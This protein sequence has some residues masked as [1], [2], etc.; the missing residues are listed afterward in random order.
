MCLDYAISYT[1]GKKG[2]PHRVPPTLME[3]ANHSLE[4]EKREIAISSSSE[5]DEGT[6]PK[7]TP[8]SESR[9]GEILTDK[10][11]LSPVTGK[12]ATE[13]TRS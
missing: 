13:T 9:K 10:P 4:M 6:F 2:G 1:G 3:T 12:A 7:D 8:C 5:R 11:A